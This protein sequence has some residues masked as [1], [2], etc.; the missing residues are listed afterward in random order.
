MS[1]QYRR[2][3]SEDNP[4][5]PRAGAAISSAEVPNFIGKTVFS[6]GFGGE[7]GTS[8][9]ILS[10]SD[11]SRILFLGG[12]GQPRVVFEDSAS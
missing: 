2:C 9:F 5:D 11:R 4:F 6:M 7:H 3:S 12:P 1:I 8:S 10:F